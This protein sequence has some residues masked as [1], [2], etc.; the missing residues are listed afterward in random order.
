[1]WQTAASLQL[2]QLLLE[3]RSMQKQPGVTG[4]TVG[5]VAVVCVVMCDVTCRY[6]NI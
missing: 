2:D 1:M 4:E 3:L 6:S 5:Y